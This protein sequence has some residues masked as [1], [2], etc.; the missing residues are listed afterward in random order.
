MIEPM[1]ASAKKSNGKYKPMI[2]FG[3]G[4]S[5]ILGSRGH[6]EHWKALTNGG[7]TWRWDRN[8]AKYENRDD[9]VA[10]AQQHIERLR[11]FKKTC[12]ARRA[13]RHARY[14]EQRERRNPA[15]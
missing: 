1:K 8:A 6:T 5:K 3:D 13:E 9:A 12:D 7:E 10:H 11:A 15:S 2:R 4:S 14:A